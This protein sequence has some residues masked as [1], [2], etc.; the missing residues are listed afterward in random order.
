MIKYL[1]E[2]PTYN[3]PSNLTDAEWGIIEPL[4]PVGNKSGW[5]KHSLISAVFILKK[6]VAHGSIYCGIIHLIILYGAFFAERATMGYASESRT[7][8]LKKP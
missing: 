3:H 2:K 8:L 1:R 4:I 5:H 6:Q 7:P